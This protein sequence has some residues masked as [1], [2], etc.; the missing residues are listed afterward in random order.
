MQRSSSWSE[1]DG[2]S[3][4]GRRR[5]GA[6]SSEASLTASFS[7]DMDRT[8]PARDEG[9]GRADTFERAQVSQQTAADALSAQPRGRAVFCKHDRAS[10]CAPKAI[11]GFLPPSG[12]T[13]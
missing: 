7:L 1:M 3:A 10:P 9:G 4:S 11:P 5:E 12:P 13:D 2:G 6:P 8:S